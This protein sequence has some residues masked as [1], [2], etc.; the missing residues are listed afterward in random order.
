MDMA[1]LKFDTQYGV[2]NAIFNEAHQKWYNHV[3][4][5]LIC[6]DPLAGQFGYTSMLPAAQS[7]LDG[8]YK[9]LPGIN[10][11]TKKA[12]QAMGKDPVNG[13]C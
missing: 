9:F 4:E 13:A 12:I 10:K 3:E 6:K 5:S 8:S 11:T 1:D 2:Q 7:V